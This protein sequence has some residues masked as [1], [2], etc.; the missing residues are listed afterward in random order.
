MWAACPLCGWVVLPCRCRRLSIHMLRAFG[1]LPALGRHEQSQ[2]LWGSPCRE[3]VTLAFL[4]KSLSFVPR[5]RD[6][7]RMVWSFGILVSEEGVHAAGRNRNHHP[8]LPSHLRVVLPALWGHCSGGFLSPTPYWALSSKESALQ[9]MTPEHLLPL[10]ALPSPAGCF[11]VPGIDFTLNL[12]CCL[13]A[14]SSYH[15]GQPRAASPD[16]QG[17]GHF[18]FVSFISS[19]G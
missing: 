16:M 8:P 1:L 14:R 9:D 15:P 11:W 4:W 13:D 17:L 5:C 10:P 18:C 3:L 19:G 6:A 12:P 7:A 2:A